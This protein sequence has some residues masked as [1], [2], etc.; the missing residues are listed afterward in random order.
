MA[1]A[2]ASAALRGSGLDKTAIEHATR[3]AAITVSRPGTRSAF[4]SVEQLT[5]ILAAR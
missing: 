4:P 2:L 3:A 1:V 5:A